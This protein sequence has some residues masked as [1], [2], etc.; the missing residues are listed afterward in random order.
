MPGIAG[1]IGR[2]SKEISEKD[3]H[4]MIRSM[5]HESFYHWG[6]YSNEQL[7]VYIGWVC[8]EG[9]FSDC[10]P[11]WNEKKTAL[12]IFV[13]ENY[14][15]LEVFDQLKAKHH[16]FDRSNA[17]YIIHLYEERGPD[18]LK[19][20][21]GC[22]CG[23]LVD[24]QTGKVFLFNDRYGMQRVFYYEGKKGFYF[25]SEAKALLRVCPGLREL[26]VRGLGEFIY[27]HKVLKDRTLFKNVFV[28]PYASVWEYEPDGRVNKRHYFKPE[29]WENQTWLEKE[30]FYE[31][32]RDTFIRILPRYLRGDQK[33]GISLTGDLDIR[34]VL[35]SIKIPEGK[36]PCFSFGG[37]YRDSYH[38]NIARKL[39]ASCQ[40]SFQTLRLDME[41]LSEF[42]KHVEKGIF[43]TDGYS[44]IEGSYKVYLNSQARKIAPVSVTGDN[45]REV[46]GGVALKPEVAFPDNSPYHSDVRLQI[47]DAEST[48]IDG[49]KIVAYPLTTKLFVNIPGSIRR[50]FGIEESQLTKRTPYLDNDLVALM[51]RAPPD[52]R[53]GEELALRLIADGNRALSA[54]PLLGSFGGRKQIALS[55]MLGAWYDVISK[56]EDVCGEGMPQW[57]AKIEYAARFL[58]IERLFLGRRRIAHFRRWYRNELA[59]YIKNILLDEK[60][61]NR[62]Y[63]I[64]KS[65]EE[66]VHGHIKGSRNHTTAI[67]K[68]L[69]LELIQRLLIENAL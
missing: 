53:D 10:M 19:E 14:T 3:L 64:R 40:Q 25:S 13:G 57:L 12:L 16:R 32:L 43:I 56:T 1:I 33:I 6:V 47:K 17:S 69:S 2:S 28:L 26:D 9:S 61:L 29:V 46:L 34:A 30:F 8:H 62:P 44:G 11:V 55:T 67:S 52:A 21:N 36:Y 22:F 42:S 51:Y 68:L 5:L 31:K 39:A 49:H 63:L 50:G 41:F 66:M 65:V 35:A 18:F 27:C 54:I 38:L 48:V 45:G 7:G 37:I 24:L 23:V 59:D 60:S 20:L 15:D 4:L 58:W